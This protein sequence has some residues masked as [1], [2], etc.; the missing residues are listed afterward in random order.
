MNDNSKCDAVY[1]GNLSEVARH[2]RGDIRLFGRNGFHTALWIS[3]GRAKVTVNGETHIIPH[4]TGVIIDAE[5]PKMIAV[6]D[7]SFGSVM[8]L[9]ANEDFT[10]PGPYLEAHI[11]NIGE[12]QKLSGFMEY[13]M[14]EKERAAF[15]A[16]AASYH[17][18]HYY[19]VHLARLAKAPVKT[20]SASQRLMARFTALLEQDLG[21]GNGLSD[22]ADTLQV[23]TTHL[24]RVCQQM[25]GCSATQLIQDRV[26]AEAKH[27]LAT[28]SRPMIRISADLG[29]SSPAYFTRLFSQKTGLAPTEFRRRHSPVKHDPT[30]HRAAAE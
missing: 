28:T 9:R 26:L 3:R 12:Q 1:C 11:P 23:T 4:E 17:L 13:V 2:K 7:T 15:G 21:T 25:N 18:A 27:L 24:T 14:A 16:D 30:L 20:T 19:F 10:I 6:S 22:Y 5:A 29:F 8:A